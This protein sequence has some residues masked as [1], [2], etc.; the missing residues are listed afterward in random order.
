[1]SAEIDR[2]ASMLQ[3]E[4]LHFSPFSMRPTI[5]RLNELVYFSYMCIYC[6]SSFS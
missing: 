1:L 6:L 2:S 4:Q 3:P 5:M